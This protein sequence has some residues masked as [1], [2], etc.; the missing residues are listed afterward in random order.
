M[1]IPAGVK[2]GKLAPGLTTQDLQRVILA[3][4]RRRHQPELPMRLIESEQFTVK[5]QM[6]KNSVQTQ[7]GEGGRTVWSIV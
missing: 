5:M 1:T 2:L 6:K 3:L 4:T 7:S